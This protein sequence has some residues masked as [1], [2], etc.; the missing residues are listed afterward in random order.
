MQCLRE[1][2]QFELELFLSI[3]SMM[4]SLSLSIYL[5]LSPLEEQSNC[6]FGFVEYLIERMSFKHFV[7]LF[8]VHSSAYLYV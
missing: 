7:Y 5:S 2:N 8:Y 6:E 1:R 3:A 4:W